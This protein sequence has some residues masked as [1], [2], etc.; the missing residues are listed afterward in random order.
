MRKTPK[1]LANV[2]AKCDIVSSTTVIP[3]GTIGKVVY[4]EPNATEVN[5]EWEFAGGITCWVDIKNIRKYNHGV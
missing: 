4:T 1:Y 2:Q 5:V 3:A